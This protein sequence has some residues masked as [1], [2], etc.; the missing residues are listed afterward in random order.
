[1][2]DLGRRADVPS[3]GFDPLPTQSVPL[4]TILRY[5]FFVTNPK[6]FFKAPRA[7]IYTNF[8]GERAPKSATFWSKFSKKCLKTPFSVPKIALF[9]QSFACGAENRLF[10]VF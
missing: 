5:P 10:L 4:C 7:P 3:Q 2:V 9:F 1:M 8:E 6:N